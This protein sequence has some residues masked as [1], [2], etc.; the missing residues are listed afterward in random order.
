MSLP[1]NRCLPASIAGA[2]ICAFSL[3]AQG[4]EQPPEEARQGSGGNRPERLEWLQDAGFGMFIH[5]GVDSQVGSVISHSLVGASPEYTDWFFHD[6]PKTFNPSKWDPEKIAVLAKLC[7]MRYVV[8]TTKHHSGFCLWNT[9]T[10]DFNI[11]NTPYGHDMLGPYVAALRKYGLA[12]GFYYSPEDFHW[13]TTNGHVVRRRN[14]DPNPDTDPRYTAFI[15]SQVSEL[16]SNYGPVD[17]FFIDGQGSVPAK[18]TAWRLQPNLLITRGAIPT[19]EQYIPGIAPQGAWESNLT[20]GTQWQYK[21]TNDDY[22]SG[23]RIIEILIET[24]AKGGSLLLNIGPKPDGEVPIEQEERL[25]EVALWHAV[26]G[27]AV[28]NTRPWVVTNEDDVWFTRRKDGQ[29]L[30]VFLTRNPNWP[31]GERRQ[32][33][34]ES[35]KATPTTQISV[36][37]SSG[38][39][40]EYMPEVDGAPRF[41]QTPQGLRIS[42]V[43][44]QR[45]YNNMK[46]PNPVVVKLEHV[47]PAFTKPPRVETGKAAVEA[48]GAVRLSGNLLDKGEF[49]SFQVGFEYQRFAG[50]AEATYN[51]RWTAT[52][53]KPMSSTGDFDAEVTGLEAG[54]EYQFRAVVKSPKITM[55]G[56]YGRFTIPAK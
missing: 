33:L 31:R 5:F 2:L 7:G 55:R 15:R 25:R 12:V 44:S 38:K 40:V 22:K 34:L 18:E 45:L 47:E 39:V 32:F 36:L 9:K 6:L 10:T 4:V 3:F 1:R 43:R 51:T 23:T 13:L 21:P 29:A 27:E 26:N 42:V 35:V 17:V 53:W 30:Y 24:R 54:A 52:V 8:L 11:M 46:W 56:D 50:T 28:H 37:G 16:F 19:P 14:L 20:M 48:G 41:E 49:S